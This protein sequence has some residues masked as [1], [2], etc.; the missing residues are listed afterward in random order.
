MFNGIPKIIMQTWK[1]KDIPEK[2][3]KSQ[4][5][6]QKYMKDWEYVLMTDKDNLKFVKTH[7]PKFYRTFKNF[8]YEIQR[9]DAIRAMFLY[10]NGGIY[11]DLDI[12]LKDSL[13]KI[14]SKDKLHFM[15]YESVNGLMYTNSIII[16]PKRHPFW[17][18]VIK[19]MKKPVP[20]YCFIKSQIVYE[21]T[22][23]YMLSRVIRREKPDKKR[24]ELEKMKK[25]LGFLEGQSW[26]GPI[27]KIGV[28]LTN[29]NPF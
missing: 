1:T 2:W 6:I 11:C 13:E 22:G 14:I 23:P 29:L 21:S 27:E 9:A 4:K 26:H 3:K 20:F 25:Y 5:S 24:L 12:Y 17:L 19:E 10:I 16:S 18:K 8:P 7:F 15:R 28:F